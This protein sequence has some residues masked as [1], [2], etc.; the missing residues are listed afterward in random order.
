M[1]KHAVLAPGW[2]SKERDGSPFQ[3]SCWNKLEARRVASIF[4]LFLFL[5]PPFC[6]ATLTSKCQITEGWLRPHTSEPL[7]LC[8]SAS[9][10]GLVAFCSNVTSLQEDL[11]TVPELVSALCLS[12]SVV[13]YERAFSS[14]PELNHLS[15]NLK[16][17]VI[18]PRAFL[19]LDKL[20]YLSIH[21]SDTGCSNSS[22]PTQA[23]HQLEQL[24]TLN[25]KGI[26][27][28]GQ[29]GINLPSHLKSLSISGCCLD[30]FS[31]LFSIFPSL[32]SVPHV[33]VDNCEIG[34][35]PHSLNLRQHPNFSSSRVPSSQSQ[36]R[37]GLYSQNKSSLQSLVLSHFSL[38]LSELLSLEIKE[39]DALSLEKT[40][41]MHENQTFQ[42]C[43]LASRFSLRSL[44]FSL[45]YYKNF[46]S[47]EL[48]GCYSVEN[49][50]L[51]DNKME[52]VDPLLLY[53][54]FN[55]QLLD[56]SG[57]NLYWNLCPLEYEKMNFNSRLRILDFS[58]NRFKSPQSTVFS[59]LPYLETLSLNDCGFENIPVSAFSRLGQLKV[60]NLRNNRLRNLANAS[61]YKL[62]S[63]V[64]LD[65]C[66]NPITQFESDSFQ[67]LAFLR[68]LQIGFPYF[69]EGEETLR[70][71]A[72]NVESLVLQNF[73]SIALYNPPQSD[74]A[75]VQNMTLSGCFEFYNLSHNTF[76]PN[77]R[78]MHWEPAL[79]C[80]S[81]KP[82][83]LLFPVLEQLVYKYKLEARSTEWNFNM[84]HLSKLQLLEVHNLPEVP[85]GSSAPE[86]QSLFM[87]LPQVEAL[88]MV[89]SNIR[90]I[91]AKF[92][93]RK[94]KLKQLVLE[95]EAFLELDSDIQDQILGQ[96]PLRYLHFS[97]VTFR[98]DCSS[99]WLIDWAIR[100]K[101]IYVFG[102]EHADCLDVQRREKKGNYLS[103][104]EQNCS[105]DVGFLLF[106]STSSVLFLLISLPILK[107]TCGS[108]LLFLIYILR[109]WWHGLLNNRKGQR[110]EYD[111][112]VSYSS[113]DQEWVLQH[114]VPNLEQK[115][116]PFLKLCLHNRDFVVGKAIVDNIMESLYSSYKTICVISHHAL[117]SSWCSLE[118]TLATYRLVA[119]QEDTLILL[120]MEHISRYRLSAY[121]R[122]AKLVKRKA[123][124]DWPQEPAAQAAF[125]DRL[126]KILKQ[127]SGGEE[128][129][130]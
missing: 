76:F 34:R 64:S 88:R 107:A 62:S 28:T 10:A 89:N 31:E 127:H 17:P 95:K 81:S 27:L 40:H 111:A 7:S 37:T 48:P 108:E 6:K 39:L 112:F 98:C 70:F 8:L 46:N 129:K 24:Q 113:Q 115:G 128:P 32:Q 36:E 77:V 123:Y 22:I 104:I 21:H 130:L 11:A 102:L 44:S 105:Q 83:H 96:M 117:N 84:S 14:F 43:A 121:H 74:F 49:L 59:C 116:P 47:E 87:D 86:M 99:A 118:M 72:K 103:F 38:A 114:L 33:S 93:R 26:Y 79:E 101:E 124:L 18:S 54:L 94:C 126:R 5:S 3:R 29:R 13:I 122:L 66:G 100:R 35:F 67:G 53:K 85:Y 2:R 91:S 120:F 56:L 71:S 45:N 57:N 41:H 109:A 63:L 19:G 68:E 52:Q 23:F 61:F 60:L 25:M 125:W 12:G 106:V 73:S 110:F 90:Y 9:D 30:Q 65:L 4:L 16:T 92:F 55:L 78:L 1:A 51:E 69:Q 97:S 42:V 20:Q 75:S 15:I 58:G 82:L 119:E 80:D 50:V